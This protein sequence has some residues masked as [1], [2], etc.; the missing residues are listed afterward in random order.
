MIATDNQERRKEE[1]K[2]I[3]GW[4]VIDKPSGISSNEVIKRLK[5]ITLA[6]KLGHG[7][8]LDPLATGVL[9]IAFG[10]ATKTVSYVME[11]EKVYSFK[12]K[13]GE[14]TDTDDSEG[15][16]IERSDYRPREEEI[17]EVLGKFIG[18]IQQRPPVYSAIKVSGERS[19]DLARKKV[20]V[21]LP[22]R[23]VE[24]NG[25]TLEEI[26]DENQA[27][28]KVR[29]GK[30]MYVRSLAKDIAKALRTCGYV[31]GLRRHSCG[32]FKESDAISLDNYEVLSHIEEG[33]EFLFSLETVLAGIPALALMR[34]EACKLVSGTDIPVIPVIKRNKVEELQRGKILKMMYKDKLIS[35]S[36]IEGANIHPF[37]V[38]VKSI[39]I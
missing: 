6:K 32:V 5:Q 11:G 34:E 12:V 4:L 33:S 26:I 23:E 24:I 15:V 37:R 9:P 3:T 20:F 29:C 17:R 14:S 25:L 18:K 7:G 27:I 35:L 16:I 2:D 36:R 8:T 1:K 31:T 39:D 10:E 21:D 30:G 13:W 19:Y 38:L 22:S 28:F